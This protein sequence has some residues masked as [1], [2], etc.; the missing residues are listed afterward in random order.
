[1]RFMCIALAAVALALAKPNA[2]HGPVS[3]NTYDTYA[4][5]VGTRTST[6]SAGTSASANGVLDFTP[7][8]TARPDDV[9]ALGAALV[10]ASDSS[11]CAA[12][13]GAPEAPTLVVL[14]CGTDAAQA[15]IVAGGEI[16]TPGASLCVTAPDTRDNAV[17]PVTLEPCTGGAAQRWT[18]S[19][20]GEYRGHRGK[21]LTA[22]GPQRR[23]GA[24][25]AVRGCMGRADQRW[26]QRPVAARHAGLD[27]PDQ[28]PATT[29]PSDEQGSGDDAA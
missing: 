19:A 18:S 12:V 29:A 17:R 25:V 20:R 6:T 1:M 13:R 28:F 4:L 21:C 16:R 14:G 15:F 3:R 2:A 23:S 27:A 26:S 10:P 9:P 5:S 11:R 24:P 8:P 22:A 7:L